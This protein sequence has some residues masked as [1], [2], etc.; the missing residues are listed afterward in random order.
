MPGWVLDCNRQGEGCGP[1][2][3]SHHISTVHLLLDAVKHSAAVAEQLKS[4]LP[5]A[6]SRCR[7]PPSTTGPISYTGWPISPGVQSLFLSST[8]WNR[9]WC[10]GKSSSL[11][12]SCQVW[13]ATAWG[14]LEDGC[15]ERGGGRLCFFLLA[16]LT[17]STILYARVIDQLMDFSE[18]N[19]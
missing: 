9:L 8:I 10:R 5:P 17:T 18:A 1:E 12:A 7:T 13:S 11:E 2:G 19:H 6:L 14:F 3:L 15:A 16:S 4:D